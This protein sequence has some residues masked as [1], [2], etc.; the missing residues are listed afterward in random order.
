MKT[1]YQDKII[2]RLDRQFRDYETL[3]DFMS[4]VEELKFINSCY[5]KKEWTTGSKKF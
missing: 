1:E 5:N 2:R 3:P 4:Y